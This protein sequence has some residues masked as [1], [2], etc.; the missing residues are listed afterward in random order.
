MSSS[1]M[2]TEIQIQTEQQ[3]DPIENTAGITGS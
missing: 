3:Q 1:Q 2:Q